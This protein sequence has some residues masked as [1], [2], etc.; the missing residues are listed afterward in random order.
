MTYSIHDLDKIDFSDVVDP[1]APRLAP[2]H[3][4]EYL[5]EELLIP[6]GI[7]KYRLAKETGISATRIG[8]IVAGRR[9]VT[10][11]TAL[12]LARFFGISAN[13]WLSWQAHYDLEIAQ[14]SLVDTI[15]HI[16]PYAY[17]VRASLGTS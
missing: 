2:I 17:P 9:A 7:T 16:K 15:A 12:R 10:A 11:D 4:G 3:I 8:E 13:F 6:L 1:N 5:E 14:A